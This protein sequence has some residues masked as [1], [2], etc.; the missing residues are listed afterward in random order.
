MRLAH[1]VQS[2]IARPFLS[3][4]LVHSIFTNELPQVVLQA[5]FISGQVV[6]EDTAE[7]IRRKRRTD[8]KRRQGVGRRVYLTKPR[9]MLT[10]C[11]GT[12][13]P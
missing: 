1:V 12:K 3:T 11:T 6:D 9:E 4:G 13:L 8:W 2:R 5:R 7:S 10:I